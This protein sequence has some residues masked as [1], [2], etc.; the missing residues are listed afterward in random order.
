MEENKAILRR[1]DQA[2]SIVS[3]SLRGQEYD[4]VL[5]YSYASYLVGLLEAASS[6]PLARPLAIFGAPGCMPSTPNLTT[7]CCRKEDRYF[8]SC[9]KSRKNS[10][11]MMRS[12]PPRNL[13][14][15]GWWQLYGYDRL[16]NFQASVDI[17]KTMARSVGG[18]WCLAKHTVRSYGIPPDGNE[19]W[20]RFDESR[21]CVLTR[22][23]DETAPSFAHET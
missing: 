21:K 9:V 13:I 6:H 8:K 5:G 19:T 15:T 16:K 20:K 1:L 7:Y 12:N 2:A 18:V 14:L 22:R 10:W 17:L 4:L 11:R 3:G 23:D